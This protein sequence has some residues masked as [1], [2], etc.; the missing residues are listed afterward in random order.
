MLHV[1]PDLIWETHMQVMHSWLFCRMLSPTSSVAGMPHKRTILG[2]YAAITIYVSIQ[3]LSEHTK[4][5]RHHDCS[6]DL[7]LNPSSLQE[8]RR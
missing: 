8:Q 4:C 1:D 7:A 2:G 5:M 6:V 3:S